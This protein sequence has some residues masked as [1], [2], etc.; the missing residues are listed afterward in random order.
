MR[1]ISAALLFLVLPV[2]GTAAAHAADAMS[3]RNLAGETC[4][5]QAPP[6]LVKSAKI[7][8]GDTKTEAG[9]V[10][11]SALPALPAD[12]AAQLKAIATHANALRREEAED[13]ACSGAENIGGAHTM[14]LSVCTLTGNGWPHVVV[15]ATANGMLYEA[16]GLP[17]MLP[18]LIKALAALTG[19]T[20]G[21]AAIAAGTK[22][23]AARVPA[24]VLHASARDTAS[25][26]D[27]VEVGRLAGGAQDYAGAEASY[28]QAL[29]VETRLFGADSN[30][31]GQT[32]AELALQVSNQGRFDE[33]DALFA[34]ATPIL[35][36]T[37]DDSARA[38][39]SSYLA[40]HAANQRK[41][42]DALKL[43]HQATA[44]RRAAV[45]A[46]AGLDDSS[47]AQAEGELSHSL[48]LEADMALRLGDLPTARAAGDEALWIV[49]QEPGL[50]LWW[51]PD[52]LSLVADINAASGRVLAAERN[53]KDAVDLDH[54][55]FGDTARTAAANMHLGAFYAQQQLYP[56]ALS[57][58][59]EAFRILALN[60]VARSHVVADQLLPYFQAALAHG[61]VTP[62][63]QSEMF[64]AAQLAGGG[65]NDQTIAR[66]A[67]RQAAATPA[68]AKAVRDLQAA[69]RARDTA[70]IELAA[71]NSKADQDR[72]A[73][74]VAGLRS[75]LDASSARYDALAAKLAKSFPAYT[76]LS[77][78]GPASL[79][80]VQKALAP[81]AGLLSFVIGVKGG[82]ALLVTKRA[83]IVR[84]IDTNATALGADIAELRKAFVPSLGQVPR[85]DLKT[86]YTLYTKLLGPFS[87]DLDGLQTLTVAPSAELASLP[88]SLLVTAPSSADGDY[89][90]AAWLI[91]SMAVSEVPSAR[92]FLALD[93][94]LKARKPAPQPM[95][96]FGAPGFS[97][98]KNARLDTLAGACIGAG[99]LNPAMLRALPPLPETASEVRHVA[100]A[101]G[102]GPGSVL[103]G[104]QASEANVRARNL[105]DYAVLYFA[106]HGLLPGELHCQSQ[107]ALALAPP[108]RATST[109]TDGLLTASEVAGL[110]LNAD[111]VVLSACNT[112][113][114]G[115]GRFGGGALEGLADAFFEAGARAV[116][117]SHWEVPSTRTA[118]LMSDLFTN[119]GAH[120]SE[121]LAQALRQAQ[122]TLI[123]NPTSAHPFNWAAFT[124]IGDGDAAARTKEAGGPAQTG[125][126]K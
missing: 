89:A 61:S 109:D 68:L 42:E 87:T 34:R 30:P 120:R 20:N 76:R 43:A 70:R 1:K 59:R 37:G 84:P 46:A 22:L 44:Q 67:A 106:T 101:L 88:L 107:P 40:L 9:A 124:L 45:T 48:R 93:A 23:L 56:A 57:A 90:D 64:T 15:A 114:G 95:L 112:A 35:Q 66:M 51:R 69:E 78:P 50:P 13:A 36:S 126:M 71:E 116:L 122:L 19:N 60:K 117:A 6:S 94:A 38:R 3:A 55:L 63:L 74:R 86:S 12:P 91:R 58:Y 75:E 121:G 54:K 102:A 96:A 119:Y 33:A 21:D 25:Y 80:A 31:V 98:G 14:V 111:L 82:Y 49:F 105:S 100:Q 10:R 113:A 52:T 41:F 11:A 5:M 65:V 27:Y 53:L 47:E 4:Q 16:D 108:T 83:L 99:P 123:A 32:L 73:K 118:S 17:A 85:F 77:A 18:V 8:C 29:E 115:G 97:G 72:S 28:R 104:A 26:K 7:F 125:A 79:G 39:L 62:D 81:D 92:A 2:F 110:N 24:G 103:L